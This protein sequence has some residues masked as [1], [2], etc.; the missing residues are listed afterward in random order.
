MYIVH[1]ILCRRIRLIETVGTTLRQCSKGVSAVVAT[2]SF[3]R[4]VQ[5]T[6]LYAV[7]VNRTRINVVIQ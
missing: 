7:H 4:H 6:P 5:D 2:D 3:S 1:Y